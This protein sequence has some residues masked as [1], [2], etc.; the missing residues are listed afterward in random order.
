MNDEERKELNLLIQVINIDNKLQIVQEMIKTMEKREQLTPLDISILD[1]SIQNVY[2]QVE[3][4]KK[5]D[6]NYD[7][8]RQLLNNANNTITEEQK[9][10]IY[11]LIQENETNK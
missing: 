8:V 10:A 7:K 4:L 1:E 5:Y 2:K 6:I 11:K 9:Q 3:L